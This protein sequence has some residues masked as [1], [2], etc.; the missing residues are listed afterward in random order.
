M[1]ISKK[2]NDFTINMVESSI[3]QEERESRYFKAMALLLGEEDVLEYKKLNKN[4]NY[5]QQ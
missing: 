2:Q 3:S 4:K 5:E 1:T